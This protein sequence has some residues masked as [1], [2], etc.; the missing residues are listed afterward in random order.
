VTREDEEAIEAEV[1]KD[2]KAADT[3]AKVAEIVDK[4]AKRGPE[5]AAIAGAR[6]FKH[7]QESKALVAE[8]EHFL[9]EYAGLLEANPRAMKR[10]LN[11]Y[12][13]RRGFD[14]QSRERADRDALV[15]WTILE[16]RWPLVADHLAGRSA[17]RIDEEE[18]KALAKNSAV[19][20]V[21]KGLTEGKLDPIV[22]QVIPARLKLITGTARKRQ[23]AQA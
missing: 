11:A 8:R 16:N 2:L 18:M 23:P 3:E 4:H 21:A 13:F 9:A 22:E 1:E 15:R 10:L 19:R 14:I 7:M 6:A 20:A 12:G 17:G 5:H